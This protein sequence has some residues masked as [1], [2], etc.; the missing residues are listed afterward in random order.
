MALTAEKSRRLPPAAV[1]LGA[2]L[3]VGSLLPG[4]M[5]GAGTPASPRIAELLEGEARFHATRED[6]LAAI[7]RLQLAQEQGLLSPEDD[8]ARLLLARSKLA[9]GLQLEAGFELH[10]LL[11]EEVPPS[12]SNALWYEL[13]RALYERGYLAAAAEVLTNV[14]DDPTGLAAGDIQL[15]QANVLM[16][17]GHNREAAQAL[18]EWRGSAAAAGYGHYNRGIALIR[19]DDHRRA[20]DALQRAVAMP[21]ATAELKALRDQARL[22]LGYVYAR[23]DDYGRAR[24]QL[25]AIGPESPFSSR[26]LLALGWIDYRQD[27]KE[28]ALA[29][30]LQLREFPTDDPAV[31]ETL[32]VIPALYVE[33]DAL[34]AA[35]DDYRAAIAAYRS[36]LESVLDARQ[37]V[38]AEGTVSRL[39]QQHPG[40]D[41][42]TAEASGGVEPP[43][44]YLT[45]LLASR[46][47]E[48]TARDYDELRSL[49]SAIER[50]LREIDTLAEHAVEPG[51]AV[52]AGHSPAPRESAAG[53][54]VDQQRPPAVQPQPAAEPGDEPRSSVRKTRSIRT[55]WGEDEPS[56][57]IPAL[58]EVASPGRR[59]VKPLPQSAFSGLP[60]SDFFGLPQ[61]ADYIREPPD[62]EITGLPDSEVLWLPKSGEFFRRPGQEA[63]DDY[64]HPDAVQR[65]ASKPEHRYEEQFLRLLP[66]PT[67]QHHFDAGE[68]PVGDGLRDL[69][70]ML[71]STDQR[72]SA[73]DQ[74]VAAYEGDRAVAARISALRIRIA[75]LQRRIA[76]AIVLHEKYT[77]ALALQNLEQRRTLL[78]DLLQEATLELAKI[79][80]QSS[81]Q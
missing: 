74:A 25:Q 47:F 28:S 14:R 41:G 43:L 9:Y 35:G 67:E 42:A 30:W 46:Q 75:D 12:V 64:A 70:A 61:A 7:S 17:L 6:H 48:E 76:G 18:A 62:P 60:Q 58:P 20:V 69:A 57:A 39:L 23:L 59:S 29:T 66:M 44:R 36:Q 19:A 53:E 21:A 11:G 68:V 56:G 2:L 16:S 34:P 52:S 49:R 40:T 65:T 10:A 78:E 24:R 45:P 33:L 80:D 77:R 51:N 8:T 54:V 4:G 72:I 27:R 63:V 50:S 31:L 13:A 22:S 1:L 79:Y 37:A 15:L 38:L 26:A 81:T 3:A 71:E 5:A 55:E 73:F 32:L